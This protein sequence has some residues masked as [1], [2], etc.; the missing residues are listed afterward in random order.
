MAA[1]WY[2]SAFRL[3]TAVAAVRT[4]TARTVMMKRAAVVFVT[5]SFRCQ[6]SMTPTARARR[7]ARRRRCQESG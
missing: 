5:V 1:A 3:A 6:C 7:M 4:T 2:R